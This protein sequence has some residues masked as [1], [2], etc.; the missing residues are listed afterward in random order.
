[1]GQK[2]GQLA[3]VFRTGETF[4]YTAPARLHDNVISGNTVEDAMQRTMYMEQMVEHRKAKLS[5]NNTNI[6]M[7][8]ELHNKLHEDTCMKL[9]G[10]KLKETKTQ[11]D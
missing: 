11:K 10:Q 9:F 7:Y 6:Q 4:E 3:Q 5:H 1:M 2:Y 8:S